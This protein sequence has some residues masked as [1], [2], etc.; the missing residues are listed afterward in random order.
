MAL[1]FLKARARHIIFDF[2]GVIAD[3]EAARFSLL[4]EILM[5]FG[6]DLRSRLSLSDLTGIP[7][8]I[9]LKRHFSFLGETLIQ[10]IVKKRRSLYIENLD[11]YCWV[12]PGAI[13]TITALK[14]RGYRLHL[15]TA[16]EG[17]VI[18]RLTAYLKLDGLFDTCF[19]REEIISKTDNKKDYSLFL[20]LARVDADSAAV[21]EDS[22]YGI[23]SS[24]KS[25]IFTIAFNVSKDPVIASLS[26]VSVRDYMELAYIFGL[27]LKLNP[28]DNRTPNG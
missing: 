28:V 25:G 1:N 21:I 20:G 9:F 8:D 15:V 5:D 26:D 22:V 13:E 18:K 7:T 12:F 16:N 2:D 19:A 23:T 3:T 6:I 17:C 24:K 4:S 11:R 14:D 27:D 10:E